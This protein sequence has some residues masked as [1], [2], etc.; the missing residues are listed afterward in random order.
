[1]DKRLLSGVR[2]T[3]GLHLGNYLGAIRQ[4]VESQDSNECFYFIADLHGLTDLQANHDASAFVEARLRTAATYLAAGV[5]PNKATLFF[6]STIPQHTELMWYLATVA[7]KGELERMT[8]WKDKVGIDSAGASASL[9]MYPILMA[10]DILLYDTQEVP[11]GDDQRQHVEVA[12]DWAE[13]F[14]S[15]FGRTLVVPK[16]LVPTAAARI[17]DLQGPSKKMSKSGNL[18]QGTLFLNDSPDRLRS[19][20]K[21]AVTDGDHEIRR[22]RAKPGITNLIEIYGALTQRSGADVE[23]DFRGR[24]YGELK[25]VVADAVIE[26]IEPIR[27]RTAEFL[28]DR[29]E[30][31]RI[32]RAG[33]EKA[34]DVAEATCSRVRSALGLTTL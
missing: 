26:T 20:I 14:N 25:D 5:N 27:S 7:R 16:A 24:S 31:A 22:S 21:R 13:R 4:W 1:M 29:A 33:A 28:A 17:M 19:K 15:Y 10:S 23:I 34:V 18:G 9:F 12:R 11:V 2:A 30:L 6:Q 32:L 8:Q 3:G